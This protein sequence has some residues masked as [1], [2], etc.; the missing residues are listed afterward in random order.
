VL[1]DGALIISLKVETLQDGL[2]GQLVRVRNLRTR[3]ELMGKV[4]DEKTILI[5]M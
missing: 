3:R 2:P 4:L 1:E 5:A